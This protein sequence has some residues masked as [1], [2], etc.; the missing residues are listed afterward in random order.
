MITIHAR[1]VELETSV[2]RTIIRDISAPQLVLES[3]V[4]FT[5]SELPYT[6]ILG[7]VDDLSSKL[8]IDGI[9]IPIQP[10]GNF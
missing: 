3:P 4:D 1:L 2:F 8:T 10:D 9:P 6:T 5:V 7:H